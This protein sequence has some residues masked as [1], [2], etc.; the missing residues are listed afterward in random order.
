VIVN[1]GK[2]FRTFVVSPQA[3]MVVGH[4]RKVN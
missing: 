3:V 4:A 1:S 2:E